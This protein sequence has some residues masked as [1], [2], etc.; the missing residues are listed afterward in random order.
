MSN[1]SVQLK[2]L[3]DANQTT[4]GIKKSRKS[5]YTA[6]IIGRLAWSTLLCR[7]ELVKFIYTHTAGTE[8]E[9]E[10]YLFNRNLVGHFVCCML[11]I[12]ARLK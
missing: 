10:L 4:Y 11:A 3:N 5:F 1:D 12:N 2:I 9:G 8:G 7:M 6:D